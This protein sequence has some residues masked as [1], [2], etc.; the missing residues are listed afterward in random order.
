MTSEKFDAAAEKT[1]VFV[2]L[3]LKKCVLLRHDTDSR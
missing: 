1:Y 2:F 3:C